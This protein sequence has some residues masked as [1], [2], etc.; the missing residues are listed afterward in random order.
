MIQLSSSLSQIIVA[1]L[2]AFQMAIMFLTPAG[3]I[4]LALAVCVLTYWLLRKPL[5]AS[6]GARKFLLFIGM[7][8]LAFFLFLLLLFVVY[9]IYQSMVLSY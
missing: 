4:L 8:L 7:G 6:S 1:F 5:K 9:L 3:A 2:W